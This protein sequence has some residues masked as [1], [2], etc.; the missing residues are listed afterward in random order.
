MAGVY[1]FGLFLIA[2]FVFLD[3]QGRGMN[4]FKWAAAVF[5]CCIPAFPL[6]MSVRFRDDSK[7]YYTKKQLRIGILIFASGLIGLL[8][9]S[10]KQLFIPF[11]FG[12]LKLLE[13]TF[14]SFIALF[15]LYIVQ[16]TVL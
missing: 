1:L 12:E 4:G 2:F 9:L 15:I 16:K 10:Y 3:T 8:I 11:H 5:L 13:L 7:D 14:F 6:Y